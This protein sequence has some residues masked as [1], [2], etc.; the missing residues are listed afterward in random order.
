MNPEDRRG[1]PELDAAH[2]KYGFGLTWLMLM[3][4]LPPLVYYLWI[5]VRYYLARLRLRP[6]RREVGV[7]SAVAGW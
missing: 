4:A 3:L 2:Q 6:S 5:C 7:G 1:S